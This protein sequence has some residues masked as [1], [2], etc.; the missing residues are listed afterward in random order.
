MLPWARSSDT[1]MARNTW[2]G[3]TLADVHADPELTA[4]SRIAVI[5]A[6]ASMK[7]KPRFRLPGSR[8][9]GWPCRVRLLQLVLNAGP[10]PFAQRRQ[11]FGLFG[12]FRPA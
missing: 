2:L 3:S 5:R 10:Q 7:A 8:S 6:P 4:T 11:P 1:P 9:V 12:H